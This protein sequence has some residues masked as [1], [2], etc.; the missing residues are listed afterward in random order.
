MRITNIKCHT[1]LKDKHLPQFI[2]KIESNES[3]LI[4]KR[5]HSFVI[6]RLFPYVYTCFYKGFVNITGITGYDVIE[7]AIHK[8]S[9]FLDIDK[10][11]YESAIIDCMSAH[12]PSKTLSSRHNLNKVIELSKADSRITGI[13]YNR[14]RFPALFLKTKSGTVLWFSTPAISAVGLKKKQDLSIIEDIISK[15][16][17]KLQ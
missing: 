3:P 5:T 12:W 4:S 1:Q 13:K 8:L 6:I 2:E 9:I 15:I 14:Q 17:C 11:G 16:I 7:D 10:S